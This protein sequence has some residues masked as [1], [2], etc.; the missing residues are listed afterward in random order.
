VSINS[1]FGLLANISMD[2]RLRGN[3]CS[4]LK[5]LIDTYLGILE[6]QGINITTI[7][8]KEARYEIVVCIFY[9]TASLS[10][11]AH[12]YHSIDRVV[13]AVSN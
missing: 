8:I 11:F 10:E 9:Q 3:P 13:F 5:K 2:S 12:D 4:K 7:S 6:V 1:F